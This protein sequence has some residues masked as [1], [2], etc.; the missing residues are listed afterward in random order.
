VTRFT[1]GLLLGYMF[2]SYAMVAWLPPFIK[3]KP[4]YPAHYLRN[5]K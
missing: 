1:A 4:V 3:E 2:G 5:H